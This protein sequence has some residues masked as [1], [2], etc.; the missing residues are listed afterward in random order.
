MNRQI[1]NNNAKPSTHMNVEMSTT[2]ETLFNPMPKDVIL[3]WI[4]Y[5]VKG[6]SAVQKIAKQRIDFI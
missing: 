5:N 3:G 6:K 1:G 2:Q 4:T